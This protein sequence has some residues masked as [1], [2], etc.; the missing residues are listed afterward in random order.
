MK[1][2]S[3]D[4]I[5]DVKITCDI[6]DSVSSNCPLRHSERGAGGAGGLRLTPVGNHGLGLLDLGCSYGKEANVSGSQP[7]W[8]SVCHVR[9]VG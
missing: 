7:R 1:T 9:G 3:D 2:P 4:L 8:N 5:H 6:G